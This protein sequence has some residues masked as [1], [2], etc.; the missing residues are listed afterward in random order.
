M[1]RAAR[2]SLRESAWSA[3]AF[4][5]SSPV[6]LKR[7]RV[8]LDCLFKREFVRGRKEK[9]VRFCEGR[10][11]EHGKER[12]RG[13]RELSRFTKV[14]AEKRTRAAAT[15][16]IVSTK[17][18]LR[19]AAVE[20]RICIRRIEI[21]DACE[22]VLFGREGSEARRGKTAKKDEQQKNAKKQKNKKNN[23]THDRFA[24]ARDFVVRNTPVVVRVHVTAID[25]DHCTIVCNCFCVLSRLWRA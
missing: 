19:R 13:E 8:V 3:A 9:C 20:V 10:R 23:S 21:D 18:V 11:G 4:G 22:V 16:L 14:R 6:Q 25:C 5:R 24:E 17:R 7:L 12:M 15:H 2:H 1:A